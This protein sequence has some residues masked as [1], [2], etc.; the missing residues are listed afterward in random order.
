MSYEASRELPFCILFKKAGFP[1]VC[2]NWCEENVVGA[3][4]WYF[5]EHWEK[6]NGPINDSLIGFEHQNDMFMFQIY[7]AERF[8]RRQ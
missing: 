3:W 2:A 5:E 4:G 8:D 7:W 1:K 6:D